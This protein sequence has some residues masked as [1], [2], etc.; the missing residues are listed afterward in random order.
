VD[1]AAGIGAGHALFIDNVTNAA[2]SDSKSI[3][4]GF[5]RVTLTATGDQLT[6]SFQFRFARIAA[7]H[8]QNFF[9]FGP[10]DSQ[11]TPFTADNQYKPGLKGYLASVN[12]GTTGSVPALLDESGL[13]GNVNSGSDVAVVGSFGGTALG[14]STAEAG[15]SATLTFTKT[16]TAVTAR[17][18]L[19]T[20][21]GT[22]LLDQTVTDTT[23]L[24]TFNQVIFST[25][26]S[27]ADYVLDNV[28]VNFT[29]AGN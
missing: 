3:A 7:N 1:D 16:A 22:V 12:F 25:S 13:E 9:R 2:Q 24:T 21:A 28:T 8:A 17:L 29:P 4:A 26:Q 6:L 23:P 5:P 20:A 11:A 10:Y 15:Y 19:L 27:E 18:R 14:L